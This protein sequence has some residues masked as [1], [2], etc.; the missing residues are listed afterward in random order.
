[1]FVTSHDS[2]P[3]PQHCWW[4]WCGVVFHGIRWRIPNRLRITKSIENQYLSILYFLLRSILSKFA[5]NAD[6]SGNIRLSHGYNLF[7]I[8]KMLIDVGGVLEMLCIDM[9]MLMMNWRLC[10]Y[11]LP[12]WLRLVEWNEEN[13]SETG[14][15][16]T[17]RIWVL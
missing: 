3:K 13:I 10:A 16:V 4:W 1:M 11:L 5:N 6:E 7:C 17:T 8:L 12:N 9:D 15:E 14:V 2:F